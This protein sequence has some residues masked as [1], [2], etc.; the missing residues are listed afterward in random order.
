MG[1]SSW[2]ARLLPVSLEHQDPSPRRVL[3]SW[4]VINLCLACS[5][6]H[7]C[8]RL[9]ILAKKP[10]GTG[11]TSENEDEFAFEMLDIVMNQGSLSSVR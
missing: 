1:S 7:S 2:T 4:Y 5:V 10:V 6:F 8:P 3:L 9:K 11:V